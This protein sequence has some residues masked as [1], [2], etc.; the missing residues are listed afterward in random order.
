MPPAKQRVKL[1]CAECGV[2]VLRLQCQ[3]TGANTFCSQSCLWAWRRHGSVLFCSWCDTSFYRRF[4]EQDRNVAVRQFCSRE[5][6]DECRQDGRTSYPKG[7]G[8][9]H[10]H[11]IVAEAVLGRP[12]A[13]EEV[14]H[15]IDEDKQNFHPSNLAVFPSQ[16]I[17]ARCHFTKDSRKKMTDAELRFFSLEETAKR[18][19]LRILANVHAEPIV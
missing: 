4:G 5:C 7:D 13:L 12:L 19:R 6:Y 10:K 15:H 16:A 14:V 18:E 1:A 17:H 9:R 2:M 3:I 8:G 11:R